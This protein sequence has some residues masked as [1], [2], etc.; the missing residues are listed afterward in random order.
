[1]RA[2]RFEATVAGIPTAAACPGLALMAIPLV[3]NPA[4]AQTPVVNLLVSG[5]LVPG[6][7]N[8][9][10]ASRETG[11]NNT[12]NSA[13]FLIIILMLPRSGA[14]STAPVLDAHLTPG[15]KEATLKVI[16]MND[17]C[18]AGQLQKKH[19]GLG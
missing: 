19:S 7:M 12:V 5:L 17:R 13:T 6:A 8:I 9:S 1:L 15:I 11:N 18:A 2:I 16:A 10:L 4:E 3:H 14:N